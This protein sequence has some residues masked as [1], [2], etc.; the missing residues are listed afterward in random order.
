MIFLAGICLVYYRT[1]K[2][3]ANLPPAPWRESRA[4][5]KAEMA[6]VSKNNAKTTS[7]QPLLSPFSADQFR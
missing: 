4:A 2:N 6:I 1:L 5:A 3:L 7:K